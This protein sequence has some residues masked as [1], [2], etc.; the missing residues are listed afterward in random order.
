MKHITLDE[1]FKEL[2][3]IDKLHES[4]K[5]TKKQHDTKSKSVLRR[6]MKSPK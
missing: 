5:Y 1:S 6:L 2:G 3:K 4:G